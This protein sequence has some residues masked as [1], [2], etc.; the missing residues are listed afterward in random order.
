MSPDATVATPTFYG[1]IKDP[2]LRASINALP[3]GIRDAINNVIDD[4]QFNPRPPGH[5]VTIVPEI[6]NYVVGTTNPKYMLMY[7][8]DD[9]GQKVF[10]LAI[11]PKNFS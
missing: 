6:M 1:I 4:L 2:G 3:S 9:A 8:V 11:A 5:E 10:V 7:K